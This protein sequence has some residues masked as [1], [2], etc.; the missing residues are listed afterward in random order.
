MEFR[1]E[2]DYLGKKSIPYEA[3][4]GIHAA[5]AS[6]NFPYQTPFHFE[7]YKA[8]ATVKLAYYQTC[9][10]FKQAALSQYRQDQI[11]IRMIENEIISHLIQSA[12]ECRNGQY[13]EYFIV[14]TISGGDGTSINM[15]IN[16]IIANASLVRGFN[17]RTADQ[18]G[19]HR[20]S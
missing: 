9:Q 7:W 17:K 18:S 13:F 19:K 16:K 12:E 6:E 20:K 15:N 2:Q 5:R 3:L 10:K 4:Y 8:I 11:P 1:V 14:P